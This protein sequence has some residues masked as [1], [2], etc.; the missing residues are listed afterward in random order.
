MFE[1]ILVL[2]QHVVWVLL[3][4]KVNTEQ[5][6]SSVLFS[7][8]EKRNEDNFL[9][10]FFGFFYEI[11]TK[12]LTENTVKISYLFFTILVNIQF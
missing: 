4:N 12:K 5:F 6:A 10:G 3:I 7:L 9:R 8:E 2:K 11:F 1:Y